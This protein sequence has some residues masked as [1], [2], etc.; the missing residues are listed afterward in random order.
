MYEP[1]LAVA[2]TDAK[3]E[4]VLLDATGVLTVP[5]Y[6]ILSELANVIL[7][8]LPFYYRGILGNITIHNSTQTFRFIVPYLIR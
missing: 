4:S 6:S 8:G 1:S 5:G 3:E 7:E 2:V